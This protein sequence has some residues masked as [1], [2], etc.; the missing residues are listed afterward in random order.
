MS[1]LGKCIR[2]ARE[3]AGWTQK[4]LA[5]AIGTNRVNVTNYERGATFPK[6]DVAILIAHHLGKSLA[7]L[8][9]P[10]AMKPSLPEQEIVDEFVRLN[11][12]AA[13]G[14]AVGQM[15]EAQLGIMVQRYPA[16]LKLEEAA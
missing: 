13:G 12:L 6:I 4:Q 9:P 7:E 10:A 15:A 5:D 8:Y 11:E 1:E 14:R 2:A 16:L 3:A